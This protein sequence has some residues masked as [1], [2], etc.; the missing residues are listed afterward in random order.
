MI[1]WIHSIEEEP[2]LREDGERCSG[3]G[4]AD[5]VRSLPARSLRTLP[6]GILGIEVKSA[7]A[8]GNM[9]Q[10]LRNKKTSQPEATTETVTPKTLSTGGGARARR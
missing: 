2:L 9:K 1:D 3:D 5:L 10:K 8:E 7:R 4:G 6:P